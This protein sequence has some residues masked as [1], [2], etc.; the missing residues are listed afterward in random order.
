L[1]QRS[2]QLIQ[3]N[4]AG[5]TVKFFKAD[6]TEDETRRFTGQAVLYTRDRPPESTV[7]SAQWL[8]TVYVADS[9][10]RLTDLQDHVFAPVGSPVCGTS[11]SSC[12]T[13][14][15]LDRASGPETIQDAWVIALGADKQ[16]PSSNAPYIADSLLVSTHGFKPNGPLGPLW[17]K[18]VVF[19]LK[20]PVL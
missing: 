9:S 6:G 11:G 2:I 7:G 4:P 1:R 13:T 3:S 14:L 20:V 18:Q 5:I 16:Q 10:A 8:R 19:S 17:E 15:V 12:G